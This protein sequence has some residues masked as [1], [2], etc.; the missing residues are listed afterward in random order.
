MK[1]KIND[2]VNNNQ[3]LDES[4]KSGNLYSYCEDTDQKSKKEFTAIRRS[5]GDGTN[6]NIG[7]NLKNIPTSVPTRYLDQFNDINK[8]SKKVDLE[9][10]KNFNKYPNYIDNK[11]SE[12]RISQEKK[13]QIPIDYQYSRLQIPPAREPKKFYIMSYSILGVFHIAMIVLIALFYKFRPEELDY[14]KYFKDVH[15]LIFLGFGL[16]YSMLKCFQWSSISI[17]FIFLS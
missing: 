12:L 5:L 10:D 14:S 16:L 17:I 15:L 11:S 8:F 9:K 4:N 2:L 3:S 7:N 13:S 6:P 1:K